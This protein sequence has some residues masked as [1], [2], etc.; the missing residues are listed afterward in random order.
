MMPAP[1]PQTA[2]GVQ[3]YPPYDNGVPYNA[4]GPSGKSNVNNNGVSVQYATNHL[5]ALNL[6]NQHDDYQTRLNNNP[7]PTRFSHANSSTANNQQRNYMG[8]PLVQSSNGSTNAPRMNP[9]STSIQPY[10]FH[11]PG[12]NLANTDKPISSIENDPK[13]LPSNQQQQQP[14]SDNISL[15]G[16]AQ[17]TSMNSCPKKISFSLFRVIKQ[18][19]VLLQYMFIHTYVYK[20]ADQVF[21]LSKKHNN[22]NNTTTS[23]NTNSK[24]P[25]HNSLVN[26][27]SF[28]LSLFLLYFLLHI[29]GSK[30]CV[31]YVFRK[32]SL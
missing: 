5:S 9:Y 30:S 3:T 24:R 8:R 22:N 7:P 15:A 12:N 29:S 11:R 23:T 13:S 28:S 20:R 25:G 21:L 2:G 27:L 26:R 19:I 1:P 6:Q 17:G 32:K 16:P 31:M 14:N 4:Y 10:R 18:R